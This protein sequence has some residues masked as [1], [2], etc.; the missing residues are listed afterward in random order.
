MDFH[1]LT[2]S[3]GVALGPI[4]HYAGFGEQSCLEQLA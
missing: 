3:P 2:V 4:F 1:G